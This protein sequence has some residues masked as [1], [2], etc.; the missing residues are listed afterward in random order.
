MSK[1]VEVFDDHSYVEQHTYIEGR[2]GFKYDN[3]WTEVTDRDLTGLWRTCIYNGP[4]EPNWHK[5]GLTFGVVIEGEIIMTFK[6]GERNPSPREPLKFGKGD[7]ILDHN[8]E[9]S[10]SVP[11]YAHLVFLL[12]PLEV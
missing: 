1:F 2:P 8:V 3:S 10:W 9:H 6:E 7:M 4:V 5:G 11:K 12:H